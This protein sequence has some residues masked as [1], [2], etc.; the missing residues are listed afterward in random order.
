MTLSIFMKYIFMSLVA[1]SSCLMS[2]FQGL[3]GCRSF[4]RL[5]GSLIIKNILNN[6]IE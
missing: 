6:F 4:T 1:I 2:L 5:T 3:V